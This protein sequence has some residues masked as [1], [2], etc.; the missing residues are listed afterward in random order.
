MRLIARHPRLLLSVACV[1]LAGAGAMLA[2]ER[3]SSAMADAATAFLASLT[4]E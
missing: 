3:S 4:P 2:A 1:L